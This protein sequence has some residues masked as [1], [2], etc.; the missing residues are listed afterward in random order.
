MTTPVPDR[1]RKALSGISG[2]L[3]TPY[4]AEGNPAPEKLRP[5]IARCAA[6]GVD[7][8]TVN[9][10][11]SEFYSLSFAEAERMQ[12][13]VP[14]L[15]EGRAIVIAGI[16]RS[17]VEAERLARRAPKDGADAIMIH[18]TPDPFVAPRGV[19]E[20]VRRMADASG[21]P[22]V[23]YL[24]NDG[25]GLK[26]I[27]ELCRI[28]GV[29]GVKWATPNVMTLAHAMRIVGDQVNFICGL[30]EPWAPPMTAL[31]ARGFTSGLINVAPERSVT[32]RDAL[33]RGDFAT[34]NAE[35]AAIAGF[36]ALRSEEQNGTNVSVVKEALNLTGHDV[37]PAR[38]PAAWPLAPE[39]HARLRALLTEW[40]VLKAAAA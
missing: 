31:G 20:Y 38:P 39:S 9:G 16:G 27:E 25:I 11:T 8:L 26:S 32:I 40:G 35:I 29:A 7:G 4:D 17:V 1:V 21:L 28:P 24:R 22:V 19:V 5:I 34:A 18:Q 3:V 13:E 36:E 33:A 30:A 6:A 12:A 10:N 15:V 37:G 2:I 14:A 23:L